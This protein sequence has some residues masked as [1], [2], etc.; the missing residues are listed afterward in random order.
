MGSGVRI[1]DEPYPECPH[2]GSVRSTIV[3]VRDPRP[4]IIY[5]HC[6]DCQEVWTVRVR[7]FTPRGRKVRPVA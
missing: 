5:L 1:H 2:C 7:P 4:N 6:D 3:P